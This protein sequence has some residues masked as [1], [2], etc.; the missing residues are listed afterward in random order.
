MS[1]KRLSGCRFYWPNH[2][3]SGVIF[4]FF[5]PITPKPEHAVPTL[6]INWRS[7][8]D[9]LQAISSWH[10]LSPKVKPPALF[11][12]PNKE[13]LFIS[14]VVLYMWSSQPIQ[15]SDCEFGWLYGSVKLEMNKKSLICIGW[16]DYMYNTTGGIN[17]FSIIGTNKR[18]CRTSWIES[19]KNNKI[20]L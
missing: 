8:F 4:P 20:S 19:W 11:S 13:K 1:K 6:E 10:T 14:P 17:N 2:G 7:Y 12:L 9:L 3:K 16:E 15:I 5:P 18:M